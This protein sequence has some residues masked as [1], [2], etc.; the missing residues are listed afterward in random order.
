LSVSRWAS[1]CACLALGACLPVLKAKDSKPELVDGQQGYETTVQ[2]RFLGVGGFLVRLGHEAFMTAPMYSNP[3]GTKLLPP[4]Q[5]IPPDDCR[6]ARF[7]HPT[8]HPEE[9]K[10]ILVGH[11]H[12]DHLMDV[13]AVWKGLPQ[14][15]PIFGS[16]T[17]ENIL[18]GY[19]SSGG[20][21]QAG[22]TAALDDVADYRQCSR[23]QPC[24][25]CQPADT[26]PSHPQTQAGT[27]KMVPGSRI[28]VMALCAA[29]PKQF[30]DT[31][32]W[33]GCVKAR[34]VEPP[35]Y[36]CD[37]KEG[38]VFSYLIDFLDASGRPVFRTYYQDTPA[39]ARAGWGMI[40]PD[41]LAE[42]KIDLML[43][44]GGNWNVFERSEQVVRATGVESVV[45]GHWEDFFFTQDSPVHEIPGLDGKAFLKRLKRASG[46]QAVVPEPQVMM[47]FPL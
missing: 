43:L 9:I 23:P 42:R 15:P 24:E 4:E 29:H 11:A 3:F 28:R 20:P 12:Y 35:K 16:L 18:A 41:F 44:C 30:L 32:F 37:F 17:M 46:T 26:C 33:P 10:A 22:A 14:R 40:H 8:V 31:H 13:V 45:I 27:W 7:H 21:V 19:D 36:S 38:Q 39:D 1:I 34:R 47:H 5:P 2:V 25:L 6:I